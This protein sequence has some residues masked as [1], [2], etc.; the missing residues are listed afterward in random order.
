MCG[1]AAGH[2]ANVG[3]ERC[4]LKSRRKLPGAEGTWDGQAL[5]MEEEESIG[6]P[7]RGQRQESTWAGRH[8]ETPP[9]QQIDVT[10]LFFPRP[11][12]E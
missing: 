11:K 1:K 6:I 2:Y 4:W 7:G 9:E 3:R 10:C 8:R 5:E 12:E